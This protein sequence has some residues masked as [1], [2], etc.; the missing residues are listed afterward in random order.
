MA[1][2][3]PHSDAA[4]RQAN[5]DASKVGEKLYH[6]IEAH[7]SSVRSAKLSEIVANFEFILYV[8]HRNLF[9]LQKQL[10]E[11]LTEPVESLF[12][13]GEKGTWAS[14]RKLLKRE[15]EAATSDFL[16]ATA[17]FELNQA[18]IDRLLQNLRDYTRSMVEKKAREEARK[19]PIRMNYRFLTVFHF[20]SKPTKKEDIITK[21]KDAGSASLK[22]LSVLAAIQLDEESDEIQLD[23]DSDGTVT[24]PFTKDRSIGDSADPLASSTWKKVPPKNTLITPM[25]C[26]SLWRQ[27]REVTDPMVRQAILELEDRE[28]TPPKKDPK[29]TPPEGNTL[30]DIVAVVGVVG[31]TVGVAV[32]PVGVAVGAAGGAAVGAVAWALNEESDDIQLD[33]ESSGTVAVPF[34]QD[35]SIG[36]SVDPLASS[37]WKK[38]KS[39]W[40]QFKAETDPMVARAISQLEECDLQEKR[41]RKVIHRRRRKQVLLGALGL[42]ALGLGFR[43]GF[44]GLR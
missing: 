31:A 12:E 20:D 15:T 43:E 36:D 1:Y 35:R 32:G 28:A 25:Q 5:W 4:I 34:T 13:A 40:R 26:K 8:T 17:S 14:I 38:C 19:V 24:V 30:L 16:T 18:T 27:F 44:L 41:D 22:L 3:S 33:E 6:D 9:D 2:F 23:E 21:A 10:T 42:G 11:A 37:T 39:L 7:A 29:P